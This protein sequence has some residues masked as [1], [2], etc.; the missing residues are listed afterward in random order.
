MK[1]TLDGPAE[2]VRTTLRQ[3]LLDVP[4]AVPETLALHDDGTATT[5]IDIPD[6]Y[7]EH[8]TV[9]AARSAAA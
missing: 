7:A 9:V 3:L 8:A 6:E 2:R 5:T 4:D 1:L